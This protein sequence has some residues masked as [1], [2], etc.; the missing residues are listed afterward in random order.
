MSICNCWVWF[1]FSSSAKGFSSWYFS[2]GL[3]PSHNSTLPIFTLIEKFKA[4]GL[5]LCKDYVLPSFYLPNVFTYLFFMFMKICV[6]CKRHVSGMRQC[7]ITR[8]NSEKRV[9]NMT[10]STE[11]FWWTS[12]CFISTSGDV[13]LC[14]MLDNE[15]F[16]RGFPN[17]HWTLISFVFSLRIINEFEKR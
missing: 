10:R 5:L 3:S 9:E 6:T 4:T 17:T 16:F 8:R 13:T 1:W 14:Q 15:S 11:Y 2:R 7:F 12:R